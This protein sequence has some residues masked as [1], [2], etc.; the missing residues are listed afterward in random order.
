MPRW[1]SN[2]AWTASCPTEQLALVE[3]LSL[4]LSDEP[5][6]VPELVEQAVTDD[7]SVWICLALAYVHENPSEF[8]DHPLQ[9]VEMPYADFEYPSEMEPSRAIY[10]APEGC[11]TRPGGTRTDAP[12]RGAPVAPA[13]P[14]ARPDRHSV[15]RR[16]RPGPGRFQCRTVRARTPAC[17]IRLCRQPIAESGRR[18][19]FSHP[20]RAPRP[21]DRR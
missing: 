13:A 6:K 12:S 14:S 11:G 9:A 18:R 5:D 1:S 7:R 2:F 15:A 20:H 16:N 8:N 19:Q 17:R 21:H 3:D 10:A 4:P